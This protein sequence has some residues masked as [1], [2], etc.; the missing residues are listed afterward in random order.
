MFVLKDKNLKDIFIVLF[1]LSYFI[2]GLCIYDDYGISYDDTLHR[3]LGNRIYN[4]LIKGSLDSINLDTKYYGQLYFFLLSC[5]EKIFSLDSKRDIY[6]MRH[7]INFFVYFLGVIAFYKICLFRFNSWRISLIGVLF[8]IACPRI[9]AHSFY[10]PKDI[11]FLATFTISFYSMILFCKHRTSK[12]LIFHSF[13]SML[14]INSRMAG[15]LIVLFTIVLFIKNFHFASNQ[16]NRS[17]KPFF[18]KLVIY[19]ILTSMFVYMFTP[20]LWID[21]YSSFTS[22]ISK[23]LHFN[24]FKG[25][26]RYLGENILNTKLPWHYLPVWILITIPVSY[27]FLFFLGVSNQLF[28]MFYKSN[29]FHLSPFKKQINF[30]VFLWFFLPLVILI[31]E[32]VII[33]DEWRHM[34]FIYPAVVLISLNGLISI[35]PVLKN[36]FKF[37]KNAISKVSIL[38]Y[39]FLVVDF[40]NTVLFMIRNH[41]HQHVYFNRLTGSIANAKKYFHFDYWFMSG[42]KAIDYILQ[43]DN[44]SNILVKTKNHW[45]TPLLFLKLNKSDLSRIRQASDK[46]DRYYFLAFEDEINPVIDFKYMPVH[47]IMVDDASLVIIYKVGF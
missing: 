18:N 9:F 5:L 33:Y 20:S 28:E 27:M 36:K 15:L 7:L 23:T 31:S 30:I 4:H 19:L 39:F 3:S 16:E 12:F 44:S 41:P 11:I 22:A 38:V 21:P 32:N 8:M 17:L 42:F 25:T 14:A 2:L 35:K 6:L 13:L 47:S 45:V 46:D 24:Y 26:V 1:F 29:K 40:S 37:S 43:N 34:Y 10:N